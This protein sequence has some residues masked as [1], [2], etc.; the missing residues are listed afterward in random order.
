MITNFVM[1]HDLSCMNINSKQ[2]HFAVGGREREGDVCVC[3]RERERERE[4]E[5]IR[6]DVSM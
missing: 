2:G 6:D 4:R 5:M 1:K 3:E